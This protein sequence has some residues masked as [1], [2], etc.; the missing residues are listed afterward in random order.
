[1][2]VY[3]NIGAASDRVFAALVAGLEVEFGRG[4]GE[5]LAQRFVDAEEVDFHWEARIE[6][7]WIGAYESIDGEEIELDRIAIFGRLDGAYFFAMM[8]VDGDGIA[9]GM[10]G[11]RAFESESEARAAFAMA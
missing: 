8:I 9:H 4:A 5:A 7:R 10:I 2:G 3:Q 6:E 1:M 11:R